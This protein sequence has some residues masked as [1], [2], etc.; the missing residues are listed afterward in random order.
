MAY[1]LR[2]TQQYRPQNRQEF[3][4]LEAKFEKLERNTPGFPHGRRSQPIAGS[5]P[6]HT[7]IWE[8]EFPTFADAQKA[9]DLLHSDPEHAELFRQQSPFITQI[10]TSIL[11]ILEFPE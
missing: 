7:L 6:N 9:L 10:H 8:C 11:E 2:F 5:E 1:I 4:E 3:L